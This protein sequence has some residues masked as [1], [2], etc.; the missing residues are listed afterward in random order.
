MADIKVVV[1]MHKPYW[2]PEGDAYFP[3]QVGK[4]YHSGFGPQG[5]DTGDN[6]SAKNGRYCELTGLYW[7]WKNL[8]SDYLGLVHY[9]RY[10]ANGRL[11]GKKKR[12]AEKQY[13][14]TLLDKTDIVLP[15]PRRYWV[16]TNYSQYAHAHSALD[17]DK[18]REVLENTYPDYVASFDI[19]MAQ[20][21]GHRFNM[22]IMRRNVADDYCQ[23]LFDVLE[24]LEDAVPARG[25]NDR[26]CGFI[27]ERLLD[28][29]LHKNGYRYL[30]RPVV[31][32]ERENWPKKILLFLKRKLF[33]AK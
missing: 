23:W 2:L 19:V 6:I 4:A 8:P 13:L 12:I 1:A 10:F 5:D 18:T 11:M 17:L 22:F 24:K 21:T 26:V 9:R 33:A 15:K 3:V 27:A 25:T 30:E 32:L 7:A 16:E 29:W 20:T 28:V 14:H 31:M